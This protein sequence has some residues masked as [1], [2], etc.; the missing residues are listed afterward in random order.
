MRKK[1]A[2]QYGL[3]LALLAAPPLALAWSDSENPISGPKGATQKNFNPQAS[4][5]A[6]GRSSTL[7]SAIGP[8]APGEKTAEVQAAITQEATFAS[9][10]A[11]TIRPRS[12]VH[13]VRFV[14]RATVDPTKPAL[15]AG[16]AEVCGTGISRAGP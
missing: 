2:V 10:N 14:I 7:S 11:T 6:D 13:P 15:V 8:C 4:L 3:A 16:A 1:T 12:A 5:S 9:A